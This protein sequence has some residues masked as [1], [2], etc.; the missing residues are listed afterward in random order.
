MAYEYGETTHYEHLPLDDQR[1]QTRILTILPAFGGP[2]HCS[3]DVLNFGND[4]NAQHNGTVFDALSYVW[5][6]E[7]LSGEIWISSSRFPVSQNVQS[8]LHHLRSSDSP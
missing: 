5:G 3:L 7:G 2:I 6:D 4:A 1:Q 8:A